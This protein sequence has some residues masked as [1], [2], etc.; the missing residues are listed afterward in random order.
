MNDSLVHGLDIDAVPALTEADAIDLATA[1]HKGAVDQVRADLQ[2]LRPDDGEDALVWRVRIDDL[3]GASPSRPVVFVD[4]HTGDIVWNY[5]D[6]ETAK[7]R[8]T[9]SAN[10]GFNLPGTLKRT[11]G[12]AD[13]GDI[14]L[15]DAHNFAGDVYD[16]YFNEQGRDSFDGAGATLISSAHYSSNY[17]NAFWN[18]TQMVYGDGGVYFKPLSESLDVCGHELTHAVTERTAGL[19]YSGESGGLNEGT[20]DI[21]GTTIETY[22]QGWVVDAGTW[23]IGED[24]MLPSGPLGEALRF[25]DDPTKDGVSIDNYADFTKFID[26][27]YSS[28]IANKA[29]YTMA[30]D[31]SLDI[32]QAA[33]IWYRA[34]TLYMTS[35]ETF[36]QARLDTTSAATD[37]YGSGSAQVTAVENAWSTV[38]VYSFTAF[39]TQTALS[40]SPGTPVFIQ[41]VT[42]AGSSALKFSTSGGTGNVNLYVQFGANPSKTSFLCRSSKAGNKDSCTIENPSAG[43]YFVALIAAKAY[44]NVTFTAGSSD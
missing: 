35:S 16:Y 20:S 9:Y 19:I 41:E 10:K 14:A 5:D 7:N 31:P 15:D 12:S 29:F 36:A 17:D 43:T 40:G 22:E 13:L 24:I 27:H 25:M 8:E 4:A 26:V 3:L 39:D 18:G 28:G 21:L 2:V 32:E 1:W 6:L 33:D 34:L 44:S 23:E 37:L 42:P 38:G 11:E 30:N